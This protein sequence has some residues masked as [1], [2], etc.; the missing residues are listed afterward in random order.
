MRLNK[1]KF[2][3]LT[4]TAFLV[5]AM[6][7]NAQTQ[8]DPILK[9]CEQ[10]VDKLKQ[11]EIENASLKE[12]LRLKDEAIKNANDRAN[13]FK[14]QAE[15]W[16]EANKT[17]KEIDTNNGVIVLTLRQQIAEYQQENTS[18]RVENEKLRSSRNFRTL[19][20]VGIGFGAGKLLK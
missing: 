7:T 12:Q 17:G 5:F 18:L 15:F 4:I 20:G 9:A 3:L 6:P 10:T 14:E 11:A 13:N 8:D 2:L 16:K 1:L 19:L